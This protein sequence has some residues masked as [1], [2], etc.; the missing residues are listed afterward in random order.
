MTLIT[1]M[2]NL[3]RASAV[4][5]M[6][7]GTSMASGCYSSSD[8]CSEFQVYDPERDVCICEENAILREGACTPCNDDEVVVDNEC[9]CPEGQVH[10]GEQACVEVPLGIG[11]PCN[12]T[13]T[14][15]QASFEQ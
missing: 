9:A 13:D 5:V 2:R 6:L 8:Q 1:T 3:T 7:L 11:T 12:D 14:A 4:A 15:C 10:N